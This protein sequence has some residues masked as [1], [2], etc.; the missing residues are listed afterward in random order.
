MPVQTGYL[1][2]G[3][4]RFE[5]PTFGPP[6]H[7]NLSRTSVWTASAR[8]FKDVCLTGGSVSVWCCAFCA[9]KCATRR[10]NQKGPVVVLEAAGFEVVE[11]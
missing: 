9:M 3:L 11:D 2:V 10:A 6:D 4:G 7:R 5:L 1:F 8:G